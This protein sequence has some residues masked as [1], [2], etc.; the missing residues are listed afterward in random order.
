MFS[1]R[2]VKFKIFYKY[3]HSLLIHRRLIFIL[4]SVYFSKYDV[5]ET[6]FCLRLQVKSIQLSPIDR[7]S[8]H[9]RKVTLTLTVTRT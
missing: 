5:S 7:A 3:G 9:L 6:G 2:E 4:R 1:F 8:P